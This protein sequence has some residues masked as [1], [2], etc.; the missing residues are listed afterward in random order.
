MNAPHDESAHLRR[1]LRASRTLLSLWL[2][3]HSREKAECCDVDR[4][5]KHQEQARRV[6]EAT[7]KELEAS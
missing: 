2:D 3:L 5:E 1:L 4:C 6:A 7:R